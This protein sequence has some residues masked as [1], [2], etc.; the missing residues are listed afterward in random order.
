MEDK[1]ERID[2]IE[3][4]EPTEISNTQLKKLTEELAET[5]NGEL[6]YALALKLLEVAELGEQEINLEP[7]ISTITLL[8]D[9]KHIGTYLWFCSHFDCSA[10][11]ETFA[12][13]V[14]E[15][16]TEV[17]VE[18]LNVFENMQEPVPAAAKQNAIT[19][20]VHYDLSLDDDHYKKPVIPELIA[21]INELPEQ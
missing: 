4:L 3:T 15:N 12:R 7:V 5:K 2:I 1:R 8:I 20:L 13:V 19:A 14:I 10:Y 9:K 16:D 17:Y 21:L 6:R 18:A 11:I